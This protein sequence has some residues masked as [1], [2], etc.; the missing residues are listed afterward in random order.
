MSQRP[1]T[2]HLVDPD[3][4]PLLERYANYPLNAEVLPEQRKEIAASAPAVDGAGDGIPVRVERVG[5][6]RSYGE[7]SVPVVLILPAEPSSQRGAILHIHGGG[8]VKGSPDQVLPRLRQQAHTLNC[9][10]ASVDYALAPEFPFPAGIEDCY[11]A[12]LWLQEHA[13]EYIV[14]SARIGIAGESAVVGYFESGEISACKHGILEICQSALALK[15]RLKG[16]QT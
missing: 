3:L 10:I 15:A 4:Y 5:V 8:Y 13:A 9:V 12:L 1:S 14:D 16:P 7:G 11:A 2:K 6:P